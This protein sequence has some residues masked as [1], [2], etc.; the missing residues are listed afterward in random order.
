[1][2]RPQALQQLL[3]GDYALAVLHEIG[4]HGEH[5]GSQRDEFRRAP[6]FIALSVEAITPNT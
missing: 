6:Q 3:S 1:V 5:L 2:A 4:D